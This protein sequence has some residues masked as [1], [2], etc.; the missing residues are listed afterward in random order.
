MQGLE[1]GGQELV[2]TSVNLV[3]EVWGSE[4][5]PRPCNP[6]LTLS[7]KYSGENYLH[8]YIDRRAHTHT[9]THTRTHTHTHTHTH[10]R[11]HIHTTVSIVSCQNLHPCSVAPCHLV[12]W[13][14]SSRNGEAWGVGLSAHGY[15]YYVPILVAII[16]SQPKPLIEVQSANQ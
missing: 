16:G 5:P 3:D 11:T 10:T 1:S 13:T 14:A 12:L 4:R 7:L 6:L 8:S 9:H 2:A 15:M